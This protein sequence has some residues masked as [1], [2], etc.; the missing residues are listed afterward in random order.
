M[1]LPASLDYTDR[2]FDALKARLVKALQTVF[3]DW[4]VFEVAT[5]GNLLAEMYCFVG[6]VSGYYQNRNAR[7]GFWPTA[8]QRKSLLALAKAFGYQPPTATASQVDVTL[9]TSDGA[10]AT[11][12]I[13]IPA[14][15]IVRTRDVVAPVRFR[16]LADAVIPVGSN[17]VS[18]VTAENSEER[19]EIFASEGLPNQEIRLS[20][21]PFLDADLVVTDTTGAFTVV[22]SFLE[23]TAVD[24]HVTVVVDELER[25]TLRFGSGTVGAIPV[26]LITVD[27]TVGGG[28]GGRVEPGT[29]TRIEGTYTDA[30]GAPVLLAVTNPA[31]ST[32]AV[33][34]YSIEQIRLAGPESLRA[35]E[36]T[37]ARE[38]FEINARRVSG[39][40]RALMLTSDDDPG[41]LENSGTLFVVP[42]GGGV[43]TSAL[44]DAVLEQVTVTRPHTVT[45]NVDVQ[46]AVYLVVDVYAVVHL[47]SG[48]TTA[49][50]LAAA[51]ATILADLASYFA[52]S[53]DDG[54]PNENV[55]FGFNY[56]DSSGNP[57]GVVPWSDV[58]NAV[59]DSDPVSKIDP[60]AS[61]FLLSG[62]R[63]DL[64]I[65]LREFPVLG[66]VTLI[67][68][69]TGTAF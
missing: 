64:A 66:T 62:V 9:S 61:G 58:F 39:V 51:R 43:P 49:P 30:L 69:A 5:F 59:R 25:A 63:D 44:L 3:P 38:D 34:R 36:R 13:P 42:V 26:G 46:A 29:V 12:E 35:L 16:T 31:A 19:Q 60:G 1:I 41:F 48:F 8:R 6:D 32:P 4:T 37:V 40:A 45:F 24:R 67:N 55:D 54:T 17:N 22:E 2:D 21:S 52:V 7:E 65:A 28:S 33:D 56:R 11:V 47:R 27:Y 15:S 68:G 23:S 20:S 57:A 18:G 53:E 14:G 50:A 10:L